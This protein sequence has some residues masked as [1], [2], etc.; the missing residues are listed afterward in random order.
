MRDSLGVKVGK[1][2]AAALL[3]ATILAGCND[4][5]AT[6]TAT[7]NIVSAPLDTSGGMEIGN[8]AS[9]METVGNQSIGE[10]PLPTTTTTTRTTTRNTTRSTTGGSRNSSAEVSTNRSSTT[11]D[12]PVATRPGGD[13]GGNSVQSNVSGM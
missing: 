10:S 8:D 9:A 1:A 13:R 12:E 7:N 2:A 3:G 6:N 5:T 11:S 4:R